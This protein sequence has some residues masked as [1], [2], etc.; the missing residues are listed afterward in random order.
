MRLEL[1]RASRQPLAQ[2]IA[3]QLRAWIRRSRV[4]P[5]TRLPSIRQL[6]KEQQLSQSCVIDA[7]DRLV[8]L[9]LLESR[10]G[11]G[12]FVAAPPGRE[13]SEWRETMEP[14]W[15]QFSDSGEQLK[16]GCGWVPDS[17]RDQEELGYAIRHIT[18]CQPADLFDYSTPLGL[19]ALRRQLQ[20]RLRQ[21]DIHVEQEQI[22]TTNGGSHALDL[23]A[24]ALLK[25][26]DTVLV[27]S[28]GYYN[29]F[30]LLKFHRV[31]MLAVPRAGNGP[32]LAA[33]EAILARHR[34]KC[35]FINSLFHNPTGTC[36]TPA[37]AHRLLQLAEAHDFL[38]VEDD[39]YADFQNHPGVRLAALDSLRR[40]IYVS[41][42]SKTLSCSLR[43]GYVLA[44]PQ[45]IRQLANIK[46]YTGI[47]TQRFA[48]C[49]VAQLLSSGAYRK[50]TQRLRLRLNRQMAATLQTLEANGWQVFAEP[51]GGMFVW[52]RTGRH[53]F[54]EMQAE[55]AKRGILLSPGSGF[56][57]SGEDNDWLRI[58]VAYAGDARALGFFEGLGSPQAG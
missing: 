56:M 29:L 49:V 36:L 35:L 21:I 19:P 11:A 53:S 30:N 16:L 45:L 23:L 8:A 54:K 43:V 18:R 6:A 5:G 9:G 20:Q 24:R 12:F 3:D 34:P 41:S 42:F 47:G 13:E 17:W 4:R 48:E 27:E 10:H 50:L 57:P 40:V 52:A 33:L 31:E 44:Q 51:Q 14:A 46:M 25:P 38:I 28:P 26:G 2:Q 1:D 22:L 32:D 39:I 7:Y 58:N 55:A 15:G 37:V